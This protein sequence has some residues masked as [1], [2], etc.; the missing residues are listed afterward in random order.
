MSSATFRH[1]ISNLNENNFSNWSSKEVLI[2]LKIIL[3][4]NG[5]DSYKMIKPFLIEFSKYNINGKILKKIRI[6]DNIQDEIKELKLK[7]SKR[8][9]N[10]KIWNVIQSSIQTF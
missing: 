10:D 4:N 1:G 9:Q 3:E 8:S 7:F 2:W 5:F 6:S